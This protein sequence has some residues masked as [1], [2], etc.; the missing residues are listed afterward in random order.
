[1]LY[2]LNKLYLEYLKVNCQMERIEGMKAK[3]HTSIK[4]IFFSKVKMCSENFQIPIR[5]LK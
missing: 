4:Y 5:E 1:M 3:G 2:C